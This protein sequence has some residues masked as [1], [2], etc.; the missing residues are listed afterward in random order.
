MPGPRVLLDVAPLRLTLW[1]VAITT[2]VI[3]VVIATGVARHVSSVRGARRRARV[4]EELEPVFE[5]F[6]ET[7]DQ[8]RL[9]EELRPAFMHMDAAHRPVA[10]ELVT[11]LMGRVSPA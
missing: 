8:Q 5:R 2:A 6:L 9:A 11:D 4:H 7:E 1:V 3:V 10:A